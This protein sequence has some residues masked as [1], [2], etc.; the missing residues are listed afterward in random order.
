MRAAHG[1]PLAAAARGIGRRPHPAAHTHTHIHTHAAHTQHTHTHTHKHPS[2]Q[3]THAPVW[4]RQRPVQ[5]RAR[6]RLLRRRRPRRRVQVG[7]PRHRALLLRRV[8]PARVARARVLPALQ[9]LSHGYVMCMCARWAGRSRSAGAP[10]AESWLHH[11]SVGGPCAERARGGWRSPSAGAPIA[12][13][14]FVVVCLSKQLF[15]VRGAFMCT[16]APSHAAIVY[17]P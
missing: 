15:I 4:R 10:S 9:A 17:V 11:F 7:A 12:E 3:H 2:P 16:Q 1:V 14:W 5:R 13:S 8:L 6:A